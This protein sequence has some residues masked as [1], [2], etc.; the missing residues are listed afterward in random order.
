MSSLLNVRL[1]H[2]NHHSHCYNQVQNTDTEHSSNWKLYAQQPQ[3]A[4][5]YQLQSSDTERS[6]TCTYNNTS[7]NSHSTNQVLRIFSE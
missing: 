7:L 5:W 4:S 2:T 3:Q 6:S 1:I